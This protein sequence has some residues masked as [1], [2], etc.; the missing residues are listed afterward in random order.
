MYN[1]KSNKSLALCSQL[2]SHTVFCG[3]GRKFSAFRQAPLPSRTQCRLGLRFQKGGGELTPSPSRNAPTATIFSADIITNPAPANR[4]GCAAA[5]PSSPRA[6]NRTRSAADGCCGPAARRTSRRA[7]SRRRRTS[8]R[9]PGWQSG[10]YHP[11][12][13]TTA[14]LPRRPGTSDL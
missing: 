9:T 13:Q 10:P 12:A 7:R 5:G 3:R 14:P 8:S 11:R 1:L 2:G 6:P 4:P